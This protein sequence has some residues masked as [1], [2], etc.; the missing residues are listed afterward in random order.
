MYLKAAKRVDLNVLIMKKEIVI[1]WY[2]AGV[3]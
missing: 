1:K 2:N 3:N